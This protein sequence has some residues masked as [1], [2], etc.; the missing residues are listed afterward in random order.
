VHRIAA[1][2]ASVALILANGAL[3]LAHVHLYDDHDH[4]EH[5]H[6]PA[7]HGH[8]QATH[9]HPALPA[10]PS[11]PLVGPCA[12]DAH[13]VALTATLATSPTTLVVPAIAPAPTVVANPAPARAFVSNPEVRAHSPP[14]LTDSPLRA[15]PP[16]LPA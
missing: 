10:R 1:V 8:E 13:I 6:G 11:N 4:A 2:L 15:P 3:P 12:P 5:H 16:A 9:P 14:G 7:L